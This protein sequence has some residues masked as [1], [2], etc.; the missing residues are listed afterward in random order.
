[1]TDVSRN[2]QFTIHFQR[3]MLKRVL[4]DKK[5]ASEAIR[6]LQ[7]DSFDSQSLQWIVRK[8]NEG[9]ST[10]QILAS[11]LKKADTLNPELR[12]SIKSD[13][14]DMARSGTEEDI[15]ESDYALVELKSFAWCQNA[16]TILIQAAERIGQGAR[17]EEIRSI[18]GKAVFENESSD[19]VTINPILTYKERFS[20]R[21][22]LAEAGE[23]TYA[24][25][26]FKNIDDDIQGPRLG[27]FWAYFGDT[28]IGKSQAAVQAGS[29]N[30]FKGFRVLHF[31]LE[32]QIDTVIERY[33]ARFTKLLT[34]KISDSRLSA[35]EK[36]IVERCYD[37]LIKKRG[38]FLYISKIEEDATMKEI[39]AEYKRVK[40]SKKFYPSV[41][42]LD[43]PH[44]MN[45]ARQMENFRHGQRQLYREIRNFTR[46]ESVAT[47]AFDQSN[48]ES[49]GKVADTSA[50]SESYAKARIV[51]GFITMNQ[52]KMQKKDGI[53]ELFT[54]K[55]K[56]RPKYRSYFIRPNYAICNFTSIE[57]RSRETQES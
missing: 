38:D 49:K 27:Q 44:D 51:D 22:R 10:F 21:Q 1:M 35:D 50:A 40:E 43:S 24:S 53:I 47:I 4:K 6:I 32:D 15:K 5:F 45:A 31:N 12:K 26:G 13:I 2:F 42:I 34:R 41:I 56:D 3:S 28:N 11:E 16:S 8:I 17:P 19:I 20:E 29:A 36:L 7:P 39:Y 57:R 23:I 9:C 46:R 48:Q 30:I 52:T 54:A 25:S 55:M 14:L 37:L 18:I 33:D